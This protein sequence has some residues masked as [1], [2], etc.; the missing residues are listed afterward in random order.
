MKEKDFINSKWCKQARSPKSQ[1]KI[2]KDY[3]T[4]SNRVKNT[5]I[6]HKAEQLYNFFV[7]PKI[8]GMKKIVVAGALLYVISP[9]DTI[10]DFIPILGWLDDIGVTTFAL[11]YIFNKM[12]EL[13]DE[14]FDTSK[15]ECPPDI[16]VE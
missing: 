6:L 5:G 13:E 10:P 15:K 3:V 16:E 9:I 1:Q 2:K 7:S 4:W 11:N 12:N 14:E 8:S